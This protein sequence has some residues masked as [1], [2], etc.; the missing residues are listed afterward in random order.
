MI[1]KITCN[2]LNNYNFSENHSKKM[3]GNRGQTILLQ[4]LW[5]T[6]CGIYVIGTK[7]R[8]EHKVQN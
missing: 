1:I 8:S 6:I 4:Y 2:N 3:I 5:N 7:E